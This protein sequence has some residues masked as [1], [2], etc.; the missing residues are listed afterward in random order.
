MAS[1]SK[2]EKALDRLHA[3]RWQRKDELD[4]YARG[5]LDALSEVRYTIS[6][7]RLV[8]S[9]DFVEAHLMKLDYRRRVDE[10]SRNLE[11]DAANKQDLVPGTD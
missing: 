8:A 11:A 1:K 5:Y 6:V 3:I 4:G 9:L 7:L 10:A 2:R